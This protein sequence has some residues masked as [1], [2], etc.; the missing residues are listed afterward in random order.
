[1]DTQIN[2]KAFDKDISSEFVAK[3]V[4]NAI[5]TGEKVL[6]VINEKDGVSIIP[7]GDFYDLLA[8]MITTFTYI[9]RLY[10]VN[11]VDGVLECFVQNVKSS[12]KNNG[13]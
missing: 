1:M 7:K 13:D 9:N 6:I 8:M 10:G 11:N 2:L 3:K 4:K 12:I 5:V